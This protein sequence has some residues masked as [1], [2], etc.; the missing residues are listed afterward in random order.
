M[1]SGDA[2]NR[3]S[4]VSAIVVAF[5]HSKLK[6]LVGKD[7]LRSVLDGQFRDLVVDGSL[8]L[9][10]VW[11]L[12]SDQPGFNPED[13]RAPF[14]LLKTWKRDLNV[15][16]VDLPIAFVD[17]TAT[18]HMAYASHCVVP[19]NVKAA[20]I[21]IEAVRKKARE[22]SVVESTGTQDMPSTRKPILEAVLAIVA[23]VGLG[24][25]GYTVYGLVSGPPFEEVP[26]AALDGIIP[27]AKAKR[28]GKE[29]HVVISHEPWFR[30]PEKDRTEA[31]R[32]SLIQLDSSNINIL[33]VTDSTGGVR[34]SAQ[35]VG[36]PPVPQIRLH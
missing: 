11:D 29:L 20:A 2:P 4:I 22:T 6:D 35:W 21:D 5:A 27:V 3:E 9:Q 7:A 15:K 36:K 12:L 16:Q 23:V 25:A 19:K 33:I 24:F 1:S 8:K 32:K 14:C 34:G 28:L 30:L 17:L 31:L 10:P 18:E 13:A 26:V